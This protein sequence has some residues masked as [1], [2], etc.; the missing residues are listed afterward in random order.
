MSRWVVEENT[1]C[2][3]WFKFMGGSGC[4]VGVAKAA[5]DTEVVI[6]WMCAEQDI[7]RCGLLE[8]SGGSNI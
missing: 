4:R 7:V 1:F 8:G 6:G 2:G 5:K 3:S